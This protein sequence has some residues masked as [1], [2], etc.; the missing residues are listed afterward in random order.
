MR[1]IYELAAKCEEFLDLLEDFKNVSELTDAVESLREYVGQ[2]SDGYVSQSS[3]EFAYALQ[4]RLEEI[5]EFIPKIEK[6]DESLIGDSYDDIMCDL[7]E[8]SG[9]EA[10]Y[11][12]HLDDEAEE[13]SDEEDS[14]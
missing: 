10:N 13:A 2:V 1:V 8:V 4:N 14:W 6:S 12:C 7:E 9:Y 5:Y 11:S 3:Q